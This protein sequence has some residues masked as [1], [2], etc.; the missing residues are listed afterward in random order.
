MP[1]FEP[2]RLPHFWH[3]PSTGRYGHGTPLDPSITEE[4]KVLTNSRLL[5]IGVIPGTGNHLSLLE[6][7]DLSSI[8]NIEASEGADDMELD[9]EDAFSLAPRSQEGNFL[10]Q[11]K[12]CSPVPSRRPPP[13]CSLG[14]LPPL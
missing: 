14:G 11:D 13:S 6:N 7:L 10:S 12:I 8:I 1:P 9:W 3:R 2:Y 5:P 4:I